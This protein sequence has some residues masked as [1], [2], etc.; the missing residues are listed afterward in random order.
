MME[1]TSLNKF[2]QA[3]SKIKEVPNFEETYKLFK[4]IESLQL[5]KR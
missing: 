3:I 1:T 2:R 4:D 5:N